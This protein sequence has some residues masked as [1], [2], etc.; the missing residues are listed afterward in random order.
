MTLEVWQYNVE[1]P[2]LVLDLLA[3]HD[4]TKD[5]THKDREN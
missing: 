3:D 5:I 1:G 4:M 2:H